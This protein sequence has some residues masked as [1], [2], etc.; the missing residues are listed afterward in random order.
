MGEFMLCL[1]F[2]CFYFHTDLSHSTQTSP[3]SLPNSYNIVYFLFLAW[4]AI[5]LQKESLVKN[6]RAFSR[7]ENPLYK[8]VVAISFRLT[9]TF[10]TTSDNIRIIQG[11]SFPIQ[12]ASRVVVLFQPHFNSNFLWRACTYF[13]TIF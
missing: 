10:S 2:A 1:V 9:K 6:W 13:N 5:R 11:N 4:C 3:S 8:S 7:L 12:V